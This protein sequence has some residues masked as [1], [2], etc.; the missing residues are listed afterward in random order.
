MRSLHKVSLVQS[1][2]IL[3]F[4]FGFSALATPLDLYNPPAEIVEGPMSISKVPGASVLKQALYKLEVHEAVFA[5]LFA[6]FEQPNIYF[7]LRVGP[8]T[9]IIRSEIQNV[10]PSKVK[11]PLSEIFSY[12]SD[13]KIFLFP[14][15]FEKDGAF[16]AS[17]LFQLGLQRL[18]PSSYA[19]TVRLRVYFEEWMRNNYQYSSRF[20]RSLGKFL[21]DPTID[22]RAA[23]ISDYKS[24]RLNQ[25]LQ[26]APNNLLFTTLKYDSRYS[27][28]VQARTKPSDGLS[29]GQVEAIPLET[30]Y[31]LAAYINFNKSMLKGYY[32]RM[33]KEFPK[34]NL[35]KALYRLSDRLKIFASRET[36]TSWGR[37]WVLPWIVV[38]Y[39]GRTAGT[40][41]RPFQMAHSL[42]GDV[43]ELAVAI[44]TKN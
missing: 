15:F 10:I 38:P 3:S 37:N 14:N 18:K 5:E 31:P 8:T 28:E 25:F 23:A 20:Y 34:V 16:K 27:S 33:I 26:L 13:R 6:V 30:V 4:V 39:E 9:E 40:K 32:L 7:Q 44:T 11:T 12:S 21:G 42:D 35:F 19:Q 24:G 43:V 41:S 29:S 36:A 1:F 2:S 17:I 22:V